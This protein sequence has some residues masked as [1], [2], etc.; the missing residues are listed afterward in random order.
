[1]SSALPIIRF[2]RT[3]LLTRLDEYVTA[4]VQALPLPVMLERALFVPAHA[5]GAPL[6]SLV[7]APCFLLGAVALAVGDSADWSP[8]TEAAAFQVRVWKSA[9]ALTDT[10]L[11]S[12][13]ALK[14][15]I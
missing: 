13:N 1:M 5:F 3:G 7:V 12:Q 10:I 14:C 15:T 8:R 2:P 11:N 4:R 9:R 6:L